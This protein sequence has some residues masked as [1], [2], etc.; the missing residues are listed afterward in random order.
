MIRIGQDLVFDN[1][2]K[3]NIEEASELLKNMVSGT[4]CLSDHKVAN[5]RSSL[6]CLIQFLAA[7]K[8]DLFSQS[9]HKPK[10]CV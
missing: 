2:K 4:I 9:C 3:N 6:V 5:E 1:L 8:I 10:K 7:R